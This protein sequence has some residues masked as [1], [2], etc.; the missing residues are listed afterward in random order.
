MKNSKFKPSTEII[1]DERL[2]DTVA[3]WE[4]GLRTD[5]ASDSFE[6]WY[7]DAS[8]AVIVFF[9][10]PMFD[11]KGPVIPQ[12]SLSITRPNGDKIEK[13]MDFSTDQF[14]ASKETCDVRI[15]EN[16]VKGDLKR[17]DL[18]VEIE[19]VIADLTFTGIV[20]S[21]HPNKDKAYYGDN[22]HYF[23]WLQIIGTGVAPSLV[24]TRLFLPKKLQQKNMTS[25][26]NRCFCWQREVKSWRRMAHRLV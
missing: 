11:F 8:T 5:V 22:D 26:P 19:D 23:A 1:I 25:N 4:D 9:T 10:K 12:V 15:G 7:F 14:S 18:H 20:P 6:W 24:I 17:Y 2:T 16:W 21:W 13:L 3:V